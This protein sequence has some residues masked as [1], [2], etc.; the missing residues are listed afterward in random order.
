MIHT[1][2]WQTTIANDTIRSLLRSCQRSA[3][4]TGIFD[5]TGWLYTTQTIA[6]LV[7]ATLVNLVTIILLVVTMRI[8]NPILY[9]TDPTNP[10]SL[11]VSMGKL[12]EGKVEIALEED[13]SV[14]WRVMDMFR[15]G[16]TAV[17]KWMGR[18][19]L[20]FTSSRAYRDVEKS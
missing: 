17:W 18:P 3:N 14:W 5:V 6:L 13:N 20:P 16:R 19:R 2:R 4:G 10:R 9:T 11:L 1:R 12:Q 15:D 7:P 8:G